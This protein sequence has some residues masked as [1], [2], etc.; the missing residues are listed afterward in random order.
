MLGYVYEPLS[1]RP[2]AT[3]KEAAKKVVLVESRL[4]LKSILRG[5][6]KDK[7]TSK[8]VGF[9]GEEE[10]GGEKKIF[11]EEENMDVEIN[12]EENSERVSE[13]VEGENEGEESESEEEESGSEEEDMQTMISKIDRNDPDYLDKIMRILEPEAKEDVNGDV[14]M[15]EVDRHLNTKTEFTAKE[16]NINMEIEETTSEIETNDETTEKLKKYFGHEKTKYT[17]YMWSEK[18]KKMNQREKQ[19]LQYDVTKEYLTFK[20][21]LLDK[22]SLLDENANAHWEKNSV[23]MYEIRKQVL[24]HN[25]FYF[26]DHHQDGWNHVFVKL[27]IRLQSDEFRNRYREGKESLTL[28][29]LD[30]LVKQFNLSN[31]HIRMFYLNYFYLFDFTRACKFSPEKYHLLKDFKPNNIKNINIEPLPNSEYNTIET[32]D[33]G[34]IRHNKEAINQLKSL[35][36]TFPSPFKIPNLS[37]AFQI[38]FRSFTFPYLSTFYPF[39]PTLLSTSSTSHPSTLFPSISNPNPSQTLVSLHSTPNLLYSLEKTSLF[40]SSMEKLPLPFPHQTCQSFLPL[41]SFFQ[42]QLCKQVEG[43]LLRL[44]PVLY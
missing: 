40:P 16:D 21:I 29:E 44:Q 12:E 24:I 3:E 1:Y 25:G 6:T 42:R 9:K 2:E 8:K 4:K 36:F 31:G 43:P 13:S 10:I 34:T 14:N 5:N 20:N 23:L 11:E 22:Y 38:K 41:P 28:D 19:I 37:S 15:E 33:N 39:T 30:N 27:M 32:T 35:I 17:G 7:N 18:G 26:I